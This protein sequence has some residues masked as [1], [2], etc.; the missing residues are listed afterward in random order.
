M[1][2]FIRLNSMKEVDRCIVRNQ[3]SNFILSVRG[4]RRCGVSA[5]IRFHYSLFLGEHVRANRINHC[6]YVIA[7]LTV[8]LFSNAPLSDSFAILGNPFCYAQRCVTSGNYYTYT[9]PATVIPWT[10]GTITLSLHCSQS[11]NPLQWHEYFRCSMQVHCSQVVLYNGL[12]IDCSSYFALLIRRRDKRTQTSDNEGFTVSDSFSANIFTLVLREPKLQHSTRLF[13]YS[14]DK[15][16]LRAS[17]S[18]FSTYSPFTLGN[19]PNYH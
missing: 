11:G 10:L 15:K 8:E 3:T 19:T 4:E 6:L 7:S 14:R 12:N 17:I 18:T 1:F 13:R 2:P 9:A 16:F 5:Y